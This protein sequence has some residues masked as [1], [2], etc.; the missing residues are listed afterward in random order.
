MA[1]LQNRTVFS[2]P[3]MVK[4]QMIQQIVCSPF[5]SKSEAGQDLG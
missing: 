3:A 1:M 2:T 5:G 4:V